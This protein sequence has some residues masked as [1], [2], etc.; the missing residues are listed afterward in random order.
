[1][2]DGDNLTKSLTPCLLIFDEKQRESLVV[3]IFQKGACTDCCTHGETSLVLVVTKTLASIWLSRLTSIRKWCVNNMPD[4]THSLV[5]ATRQL[6]FFSYLKYVTHHRP[7]FAVYLHLKRT[8]GSVGQT[9]L[10]S[11][12]HWESAPENFINLL[13]ALYS[14]DGRVRYTVIHEVHSKQPAVF[15]SGVPS[16]L[17][18]LRSSTSQ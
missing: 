13:R 9:A 1:M 4:F 8:F 15:D 16:L 17:P 5:A 7:T 10:L 6:P 3:P 2:L 11:V 12:V 18:C 14:Y